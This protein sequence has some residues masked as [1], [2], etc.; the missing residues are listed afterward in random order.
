MNC[1]EFDDRLY[2]QN[3]G[4]AIGTKF[5]PAIANLF[6]ARLEENLMET[7]PDTSLT[8][9]RLIDDV[10]FNWIHG[11]EELKSYINHLNGSHETVKSTSEQ[12][13]DNISLF[14]FS[15]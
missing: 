7:P 5:A 9:T 11:K 15:I 6:V 1:F 10:F 2:R 12:S 13:R 3:L 8:R 14:R 4:T